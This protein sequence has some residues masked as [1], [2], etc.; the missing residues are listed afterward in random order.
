MVTLVDG[1]DSTW[2]N[3]ATV[4]WD[5]GE[6]RRADAAFFAS[7]GVARGL[8][9]SVTASD[10]ARVESGT[11]VIDG[12]S[13]AEGT[14][15]YRGGT[16]AQSSATLDPRDAT[17]GRIDLVI[18]RQYDPDVVAA[19]STYEGA[20]EVITGAPSASPSA[21]ALPDLAIELARLDVPVD[22]GGAVAVDTSTGRTSAQTLPPSDTGPVPVAPLLGGWSDSAV[23]IRRVGEVVSTEGLFRAVAAGVPAGGGYTGAITVLDAEF[24]PAKI[25][26]GITTGTVFNPTQG[27]LLVLQVDLDGTVTLANIGTADL[28][29]NAFVAWN[30]TWLAAD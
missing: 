16:S 3:D 17:Y 12:E 5:A 24:R 20:V 2:V 7:G 30:M 19:H 18:A 14:G 1:L 29:G 8:E 26:F 4:T 9:V 13:T 21:P 6:L 23:T 22:G 10:V 28:P 15:V 11:W 25:Q 27:L